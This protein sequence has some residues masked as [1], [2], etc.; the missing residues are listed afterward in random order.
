MTSLEDDTSYAWIV[1]FM[2]ITGDVGELI[3]DESSLTAGSVVVAERVKV[4][5]GAVGCGEQLI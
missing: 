4:R 1:T 2:S 3:V 5:W